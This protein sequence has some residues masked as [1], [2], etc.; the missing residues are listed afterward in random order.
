MFL[1]NILRDLNLYANDQFSSIYKIECN[2][3]DLQSQISQGDKHKMTNFKVFLF[4]PP[5]HGYIEM[6]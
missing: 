1:I 4:I 6:M 2:V 3:P 5:Q